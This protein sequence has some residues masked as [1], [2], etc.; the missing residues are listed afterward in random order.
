MFVIAIF[1]QI[2]KQ[3]LR[4]KKFWRLF[5]KFE[6]KGKPSALFKSVAVWAISGNTSDILMYGE[7]RVEMKLKQLCYVPAQLRPSKALT[8]DE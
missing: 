5:P 2:T 1:F 4:L 8:V 6:R 7:I 3:P